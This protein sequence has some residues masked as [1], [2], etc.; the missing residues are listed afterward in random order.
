MSPLVWALGAGGI[1]GVALV[2]AWRA[3]FPPPVGLAEALDGLHRLAPPPRPHTPAGFTGPW[4]TRLGRLL[5]GLSGVGEASHVDGD[6][7][8]IGRAP[9]HHLGAKALAAIVGLALP[10]LWVW[11]MGQA[12]MV[13]VAPG[14]ALVMGVLL[15][16]A[17]WF[18]PDALVR[19]QAAERRGGF[20]STFGTFLDMVAISLAGGVGIEGALADAARVGRGREAAVLRAALEEAA[21]A[22]RSQ[23]E[24]LRALGL[25]LGLED[26]VEVA[27]TVSLAG[28]EGARVRR[29]L[30]AKARS[31]RARELATAQAKAEAATERMAIPTALLMLGFLLLVGYPSL[32]AVL[33]T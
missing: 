10:V 6:L 32:M 8:V 21:R 1:V 4:A 12:A 30:E 33:A 24:E 15:A 26:L 17:G 29:S 25:E 16:T 2:G 22:G 9:E 13:A 19:R 5:S 3:L 11:A 23:W 20:V 14:L 7:R 31:M 18:V 27:A 28:T